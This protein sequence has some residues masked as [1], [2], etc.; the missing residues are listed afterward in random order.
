MLAADLLHAARALRAPDDRR[1]GPQAQ[2]GADR[3]ARDA[4]R[5]AVHPVLAL[6][7]LLR[8]GH[9]D[10]RARDLQPRRPLGARAVPGH[11]ARQRRTPAT[12]STS[13]RWGRSP[14]GTS[15]SR[16]ASGTWTA[17]SRSVPGCARGCNIEVHTNTKRAHHAQGRRVV[18]LKPRFNADVNQWWMCD[19]GRYGFATSTRRPGIERPELRESG[20]RARPP[21]GRGAGGG[22]A[23]PPRGGAR[24]HRR[25]ALA[26]DVERGPLARAGACS[27]TRSA[28]LTR[29]SGCRRA[30]P[31]SQDDL[32]RVADKPQHAAAPKL[33]GVGAAGGGRRAARPRGRAGGSAP[34]SL[35]VRPRPPRLGLARGGGGGG[36]RAGRGR[37]LPGA[38]RE[39]DERAGPRGPAE[40][41]LRRAGG[42]L[43]ERDGPGPAVLAR[44]AAARRGAR[45][46]GDP[47]SGRPGARPRLAAARAAANVFRDLA[48][49]RP[50]VRRPELP[51]PRGPRG[52]PPGGARS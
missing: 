26:P 35:G 47:G 41:G 39:R 43:D 22:G 6:R 37:R 46:L 49:A 19:E 34:A 42:H 45:G 20:A 38:E 27:W 2:G 13:A 14:T 11:D 30:R 29:T 50:G 9:Q 12:S 17:R 48:A 52:A 1:Q 16:P 23:G 36:A 7:P 18:R 44:R 40:R 31:G 24:G 25:A 8:H 32:L 33:L 21:V 4:G 51:R 10:R 5:R 3:A 15:A 28:S